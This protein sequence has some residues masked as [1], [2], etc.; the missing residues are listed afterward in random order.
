MLVASQ[1]LQHANYAFVTVQTGGHV[2]FNLE[3]PQVDPVNF[4][5]GIGQ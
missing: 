3:F 5:E 2:T 1:V 4:D